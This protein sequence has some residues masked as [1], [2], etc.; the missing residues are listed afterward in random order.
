MWGVTDPSLHAYVLDD[1]DHAILVLTGTVVPGCESLLRAALLESERHDHG[2]VIVDV[3]H[4]TG[5]SKET[6]KVLL[7]ELGRAFDDHRTLRLVVRDSHQKAFL[8]G[9][10]LAGMLPT[11]TTLEEAMA[12]A[13][14]LYAR[15]GRTI[16]L[17]A[18][19]RRSGTAGP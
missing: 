18:D 16:D 2:H 9:L 1:P 13:E 14:A 5:M 17:D 8:D 15:T 4:V 6:V 10:G 12:A 19:R 11:H 7:W 3:R